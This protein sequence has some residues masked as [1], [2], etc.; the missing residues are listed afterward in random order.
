MAL[1]PAKPQVHEEV[2]SHEEPQAGCAVY[3]LLIENGLEGAQ[4]VRR[5]QILEPGL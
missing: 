3:L 5:V 4:Q 2:Q 1:E